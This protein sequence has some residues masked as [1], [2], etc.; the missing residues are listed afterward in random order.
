MQNFLALSD[1]SGTSRNVHYY[2]SLGSYYWVLGSYDALGPTRSNGMSCLSC[3]RVKCTSAQLQYEAVP[4]QL[5][6]VLLVMQAQGVLVPPHLP[7]TEDQAKLW[8]ATWARI[9]TFLPSLQLELFPSPGKAFF[10]PGSKEPSPGP[11]T[12]SES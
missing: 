4:E 6:N 12:N 7:R 11:V 8:D 5:K 3:C 1:L 2:I 10:R 9:D